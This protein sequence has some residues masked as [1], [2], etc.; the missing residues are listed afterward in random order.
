MKIS[1]FNLLEIDVYDK[2]ELIFNGRVENASEELK[3]KNVDTGL[4]LERINMLLQGKQTPYDTEIF[5]P[6][7]AKIQELS[8]KD[9]LQS[10]RIVAEHLRSSIMIICDGGRPSNVD[11]GYVLRRLIRRMTRHLNK[12]K[13][14][15]SKP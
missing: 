2:D 12:F 4:G 8:K 10:T 13:G 15:V 9:N 11:R 3:Q 5:A 14:Y 6:I 7:M 1:E